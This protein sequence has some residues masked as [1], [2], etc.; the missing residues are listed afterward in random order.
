MLPEGQTSAMLA[1]IC[2]V[3]F[4]NSAN[5][6]LVGKESPSLLSYNHCMWACAI[7]ATRAK[8]PDTTWLDVWAERH[9]EAK[10]KELEEWRLF[11]VDL[12]SIST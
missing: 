12:R 3:L 10:P 1:D 11:L 5:D 7:R 8:L 4:G 2:E 9:P 6:K